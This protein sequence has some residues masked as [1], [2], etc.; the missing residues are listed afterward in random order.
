[1]THI[2]TIAHTT[3]DWHFLRV[4]PG[5]SSYE[6]KPIGKATRDIAVGEVL[7]FTIKGSKVFS[8]D[9]KLNENGKIWVLNKVRYADERIRRYFESTGWKVVED[10]PVPEDS[11]SR[12]PICKLA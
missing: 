8:P 9:M 6:N 5:E 1:M 3:R 12:L 10:K 7:E 4:R 2:D 11:S